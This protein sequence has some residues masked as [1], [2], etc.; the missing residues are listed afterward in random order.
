LRAG[1]GRSYL[2]AMLLLRCIR[3][4]IRRSKAGTWVALIA[5]LLCTGTL[6]AQTV[7]GTVR[8]SATHQPIA[9]AVLMLLDSSGVVLGRRVTDEN[10]QYRIAIT[11]ASRWARVVRI[12]FQPR[13]V[14]L[15]GAADGVAPYDLAMLRVPT[16][17]AAVDIRDQSR[18]GKRS[19]RAAALGLWE[20]AR[21]GLLATVVAR[22]TNTA[23][24]NRLVFERSFDGVSDK[25]THFIVR[26]DSAA[27]A[28]KSFNASRSA[29][30]FIATGFSS[31]SANDRDL[32]GPDA[33][34]LLD[35]AFAAG[36]CFRLAGKVKS[37]PTEVG[38]AFSPT[39]DHRPGGRVDIDGTLWVDTA[40][41]A[42][43]DIEYQYVGLPRAMDEY[44]PGGEVSFR[45]MANGTVMI[46][47][48]YIRGVG[49]LQ[50]TVAGP[51]GP[52]P[53]AWLFASES[54]GDLARATW[55]DGQSWR[56]PLG[57]LRLRAVTATGAP[58]PGALIA[59]PGTPY[60]GTADANG[61]IRIAELEP[62]PYTVN[63]LTP[64]LA[65]I[66][67]AIPTALKFV[68]VRDS[69]YRATLKVPRPADWVAGRCV[70]DH[71][72]DVRDSVFVVGRVVNS[73][74]TPVA[75]VTLRFFVQA[76]VGQWSLLSD[77]Y[78]TGAD[79]VF[80]S[81]SYTY[82]PGDAIRVQASMPGQTPFMTPV[83]L[84]GKLNTILVHL[85]PA[86]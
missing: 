19:D 47:H 14:R 9:G 23:S 7:Y 8:D 38:L 62:G 42:I 35:D 30:D 55:P 31:D 49:A 40:A 78:T 57:S 85:P 76:S 11:G 81:C 12:G 70:A 59:L 86:S 56:A 4:V 28:S 22:E 54:G 51:T 72:W 73:R 60:S 64:P 80:Q 71:Q 29:R 10:G 45:Q 37:R 16:M 3:T 52:H 68:A 77:F 1:A 79:G 33:D 6:R 48:W 26:A 32:Y 15:S 5:L 69:T 20:Q 58:A 24:V 61:E 43:R 41:R 36:Y 74:G 63:V 21:A 17:L 83:P 2:R 84:S 82:V 44:R 25:I 18:C 65:D 46:D 50:D 13:E 39:D 27:G 66:G 34:V 75:G 53:R 67:V